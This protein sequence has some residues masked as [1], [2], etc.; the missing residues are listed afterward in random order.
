MRPTWCFTVIAV[1]GLGCA[2]AAF[3]N[4]QDAAANVADI[5]PEIDAG[6]RSTETAPHDTP[7]AEA[8][9]VPDRPD[10]EPEDGEAPAAPARQEEGFLTRKAPP[11]VTLALAIAIL[12]NFTGLWNVQ[13][14]SHQ[15]LQTNE[16]H[17]RE[18]TALQEFYKRATLQRY[19]ALL[20][21]V[22]LF[23]AWYLERQLPILPAILGGLI[24]LKGLRMGGQGRLMIRAVQRR[25]RGSA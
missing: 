19:L 17:Q 16:L 8:A 7:P 6:L 21:S 22:G 10:G 1:A 5:E 20:L 2:N 13:Q 15:L 14:N 23:V 4:E 12:L 9:A 11:S 25:I 18:R 3:G 24:F